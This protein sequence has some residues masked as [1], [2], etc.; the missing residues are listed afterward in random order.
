MDD[1]TPAWLNAIGVLLG[2]ALVGLNTWVTWIA[3]AGGTRGA[4]PVT[5]TSGTSTVHQRGLSHGH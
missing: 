4:T 2:L 1:A 3:L 5:F